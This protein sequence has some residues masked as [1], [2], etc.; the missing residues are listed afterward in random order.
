MNTQKKKTKNSK[1]NSRK[2]TG[3]QFNELTLERDGHKCLFCAETKDLEIHHILDRSL[4]E[5]G[6]YYLNNASTLCPEH[7]LF[8]EQGNLSC[9]QIRERIP[10]NDIILPKGYDTSLEYNKWGKPIRELIKYPR[11][12]HVE[13]SSLQRGDGKNTIPFSELMGKNLVVEAKID[14]AN[15][16]ISFNSDCELKLQCRGHFLDGKGDWPEFDPF[17]SWAFTWKN[18]LFD[19]LSD[20]YIMYGEWMAAFHSIYYD[21][22]PH[23]FME[24]DIYDKERQEFLSTK[25]RAEITNN[26]EAIIESVKVLDERTFDSVEEL[27]SLIGRSPFISDN[28][29]D[30]MTEEMKNKKFP[31]SEIQNLQ[32]LNKNPTMEGLYVKWEE[33]G[34]VKGRYKF[35][36]ADFTQTI[37]DCEEHWAKRPTIYNQLADGYG[38]YTFKEQK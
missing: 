38:L 17:K 28:A 30:K 9:R 23:W 35:V 16:G 19:V 26:C 22:L 34:V 32:N 20:R 13:G 24:F 37:L 36:R 1:T 33:D 10:V 6:G 4:F 25:R 11:T 31:E 21:L 12:T 29:Y 5:D 15:T 18:Q 2:E 14:G 27:T 7:H 8:A 3:Q